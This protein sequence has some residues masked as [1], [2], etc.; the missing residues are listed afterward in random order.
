MIIAIYGISRSGKDTFI[1]EVV[2]KR[3]HSFHLKGS[4]KLNE[5]AYNKYDCSFKELNSLKQREIR[6]DF[7]NYAKRLESAYSLVLVD[8]HYSFPSGTDFN[9]VFTKEDLELY[10]AF[11]YLKRTPE[12]ISRN[13]R[14][15]NKD[16]Y[17]SFLLDKVKCEEWINFEIDNMKVAVESANKD[18]IV[19]DSD[20]IS[21]S[22][23]AAFENKSSECARKIAD[24]IIAMASGGK[25]VLTDLDKTVSIND[26]TDDFMAKAN[27]DSRF[28]KVVFKGDYYTL[29]QFYKF[30]NWLVNIP[31]YDEAVLHSLKHLIMNEHVLNDLYNLKKDACV[32]ALTTGLADVWD[33]MNQE[34]NV[35]DKIYGFRKKSQLLITPLIKKLIARYVALQYETIAIG[36]SIIDLGMLSESTK[37]YFVSMTKLDKRVIAYN[38]IAQISKNIYQPKYSSFKYDFIREGELKW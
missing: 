25:V 17:A 9:T 24:E 31:N 10:D 16:N 3:A 19:L 1:S 28:P 5:I 34:L 36:D 13:F 21:S 29:Y 27:L 26:L 4:S 8:G 35:F 37:G 23:V 7:T 20:S 38:E 18:F 12:E 11:F 14:N 30:H 2:S 22:F 32:I 15:G 6:I 33:K